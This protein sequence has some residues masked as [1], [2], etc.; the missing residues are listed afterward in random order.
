MMAGN[1]LITYKEV[2]ADHP[3]MVPL[4]LPTSS[5]SST[6]SSLRAPSRAFM[7]SRGMQRYSPTCTSLPESSSP[8]GP[9]SMPGSSLGAEDSLGRVDWV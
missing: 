5:T 8:H 2:D 9:T 3:G 6:V 1:Y 4:V 7:S